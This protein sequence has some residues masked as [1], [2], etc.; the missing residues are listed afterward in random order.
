[1]FTAC[2]IMH[3]RCCLLAD[4]IAGAL[5]HKLQTQSIAPED[6]LNYRTKH[7]ELI[8]IINKILLLLHLV[9]CL[10]YCISDARSHKYQTSHTPSASFDRRLRFV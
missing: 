7:V 4:S 2:G 6:G 3:R 9:G 8:V 10:Y 5:Y 1:M